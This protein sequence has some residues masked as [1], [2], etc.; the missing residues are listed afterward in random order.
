MTSVWREWSFAACWPPTPEVRI[1][2]EARAAEEAIRLIGQLS[3]DLIFL[4]IEMP[5]MNGFELLERLE[6]CRR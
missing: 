5:G 3:P 4:D 1:L 2:G 6:A